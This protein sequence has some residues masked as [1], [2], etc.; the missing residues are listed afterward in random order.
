[1]GVSQL[2]RKVRV[3][4]DDRKFTKELFRH[5]AIKMEKIGSFVEGK[6][7]KSISIDQPVRRM[8]SGAL[9]GLNPSKPGHPPHVLYGRLRQSI[10]HIVERT[11]TSVSARVGTNVEY[12]KA[13]EFGNPDTGMEPRPF[14]RPG[15]LDN[16]KAILGMLK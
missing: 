4:F 14:L 5:L 15:V 10:T 7:V 8:P 3:K 6:V 12:A 16:K 9:V 1:M 2:S 13:L 11:R